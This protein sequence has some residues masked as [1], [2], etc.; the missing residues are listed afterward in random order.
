[1]EGRM[2][3]VQYGDGTLAIS[4]AQQPERGEL[5]WPPHQL[6]DCMHAYLCLLRRRPPEV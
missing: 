3:V 1:M 5:R 6:D 4:F 2:S